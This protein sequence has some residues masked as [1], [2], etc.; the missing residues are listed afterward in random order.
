MRSKSLLNLLIMTCLTAALVQCGKE[1]ADTAKV[2][3]T[4]NPEKPIVIGADFSYS[5][6]PLDSQGNPTVYKVTGPWFKF[7]YTIKND[8]DQQVTIAAIKFTITTDDPTATDYTSTIEPGSL[9][10]NNNSDT[11]DDQPYL[12]TVDAHDSKTT[13]T[14]WYI[15]GL[16]ANTSLIYSVQAKA[17]GWFGT[18]DNPTK[19]FKKTLIFTTSNN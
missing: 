6:L 2:D 1:D 3:F 16:P 15:G 10:V 9:V 7:S 5:S 18:P 19:S 8:S 14:L 13:D 4:S 12:I 17:E 11:S